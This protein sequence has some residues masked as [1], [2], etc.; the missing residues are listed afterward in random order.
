[1]GQGLGW[2]EGPQLRGHFEHNLWLGCMIV[3]LL[4]LG[5]KAIP[6]RAVHSIGAVH[7]SAKNTV[8]PA[9]FIPL[10]RAPF[11]STS[12][13][14]SAGRHSFHRCY[15]LCHAPFLVPAPSTL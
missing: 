8:H 9:G 1:M 6:L 3:W 2:A 12:A 14:N 11:F 5:A 7:F 10:C 15:P 4:E 13:I